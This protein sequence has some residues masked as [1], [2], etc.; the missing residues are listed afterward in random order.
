[1]EKVG[2]NGL[3]SLFYIGSAGSDWGNIAKKTNH[4]LALNNSSH[5][6]TVPMPPVPFHSEWMPFHKSSNPRCSNPN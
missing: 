5:P 2:K 1:M 4:Q 3:L 6:K